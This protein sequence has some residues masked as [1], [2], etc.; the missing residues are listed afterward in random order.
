[1]TPAACTT[2]GGDYQGGGTTC[3]TYDCSTFGACCLPDQNCV[4]MTASACAFQGGL[5]AGDATPCTGLGAPDCSVGD[6]GGTQFGACQTTENELLADLNAAANDEFGTA[7]ALSGGLAVV[8]A[9]G[10]DSPGPG[11]GSAHLFRL[12]AANCDVEQFR[13]TG[14]DSNGGDEFGFA[15]A[16]R[17]DTAVVGA[18]NT[19]NEEL[20]NTGSAYVF[21]QP[22]LGWQ[23][24]FQNAIL[25]KSTIHSKD[26]FAKSVAIREDEFVVLVGS[27]GECLAGS[28]CDCDPN[29]FDFGCGAV[30]VFHKPLFGWEDK[31]EDS[32][33]TADDGEV[34]DHF[35]VSV[36]L[37]GT[38]GLVGA[39]WEDEPCGGGTNCDAGAAYVFRSNAT[40]WNWIQEAK[41]T[42]ADAQSG[43]EFGTSVSISGNVAIVG[44]PF[45]DEAAADDVGSAYVFRFDPQS[46]QWNQEARLTASDGVAFD[47][48]GISV[49][50][51][52]DLAIVGAWHDD[53]VCEDPEFCNS[54]SAYVF[55]FNGFDWNEEAKL[56]ASDA[57]AFDS[58]G[59]SV[60]VDG[61]RAVAGAILGEAVPGGVT[62]SGAAYVFEGLGDCDESQTTDLCDILNNPSLDCCPPHDCCDSTHGAGCSNATIE[63]C[64]CKKLGACCMLWWSD[65]CV[66]L[67]ESLP[68]CG[69]CDPG[70]NGIIDSCEDC[71]ADFDGDGEV[72][73]ADLA[74]LLG[75][76]GPCPGGCPEDLSGDCEVDSFDLAILLGSWGL[77]PDPLTA[78]WNGGPDGLGALRFALG[79]GNGCLSLEEAVQMMGHDDVAAFIEWVLS[80]VP[81]DWVYRV[82]Q[83]LLW[84]LEIWPC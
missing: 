36:S 75:A 65:E 37:S 40:G 39:P 56:S 4:P 78:Q 66:A 55:R 59:A 18:P 6:D 42:A 5:Y 19:F 32:I 14:S 72:D 3:T 49:S 76:W 51:S 17:G 8:G 46:G 73:A 52:G 30:F 53:E 61:D 28:G 38:A 71:M 81:P 77:C 24:M 22:P 79:G 69:A 62:N 21:E 67:V 44:S 27:P 10:D 26:G 54:G 11:T 2:A 29:N 63:K 41:L 1:M 58:F 16:L 60:S 70:G 13:L 9:P 48:F 25:N 43:D 35:G 45:D 34:A 20:N 83:F 57:S 84:L 7:V 68:A 31:T 50:I 33:I 82:A 64:V 47:D 15:V 12:G 80:E 74:A 23:D